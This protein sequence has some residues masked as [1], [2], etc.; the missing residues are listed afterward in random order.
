[1]DTKNLLLLV[2]IHGRK[3]VLVSF[4]RAIKQNENI[5]ET[6]KSKM[7]VKML[8]HYQNRIKQYK[9]SV[10]KLGCSI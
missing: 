10:S 3:M 9:V 7:N 6:Y 2:K 5:V 8:N 1:M 4:L